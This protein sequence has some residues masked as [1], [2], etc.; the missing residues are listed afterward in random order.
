[1]IKINLL[2]QRRAKR[3]QGSAGGQREMAIG[4]G[5]LVVVGAL[6]YVAFDR[7]KRVEIGELDASNKELQKDIATKN[8]QLVDYP[9]LK[10]AMDDATEREGQTVGSNLYRSMPLLRKALQANE[11]RFEAKSA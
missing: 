2:P 5:A 9:K 8:A 7:P 11:T 1:M 3:A 6:L 4:I 10:A